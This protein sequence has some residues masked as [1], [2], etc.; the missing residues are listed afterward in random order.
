MW[1]EDEIDMLNV[2]LLLLISFILLGGLVV[3]VVLY[4]VCVIMWCVEW[5]MVVVVELI[6]L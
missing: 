1:L 4:L 2:E 6:N 3:V 5:L